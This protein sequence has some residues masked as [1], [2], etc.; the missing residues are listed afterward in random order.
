[1]LKRMVNLMISY[2]IVFSA[3][4]WGCSYISAFNKKRTHT[5]LYECRKSVQQR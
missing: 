5:I 4:L 3:I 1:M 2:L